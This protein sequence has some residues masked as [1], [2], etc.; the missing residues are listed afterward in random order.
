MY[1]LALSQQPKG[2]LTACDVV[3]GVAWSHPPGVG[4]TDPGAGRTE[5]LWQ[6]HHHA[7]TA[8]LL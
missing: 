8:A 2:E 3:A 4:G 7:T 5:R 6:E 1:V